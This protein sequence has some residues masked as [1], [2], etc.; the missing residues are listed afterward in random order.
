MNIRL[1]DEIILLIFRHLYATYIQRV[2]RENRLFTPLMI[3]NRVVIKSYISNKLKLVY[4]TIYSIH[5]TYC[6]IRLFPRL[7]PRWRLCNIH[8][9]CNNNYNHNDFPYY[10]PRPIRVKLRNIIKLHNWKIKMK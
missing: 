3:G 5:N 1:P 7:I 10:N 4:G 6:R 2:F 8:F 9:W